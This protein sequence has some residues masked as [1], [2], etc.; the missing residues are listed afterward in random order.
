MT[1]RSCR[2]TSARCEDRGNSISGYL[3]LIHP[4]PVLFVMVGTALFGLLAADGSPE[5]PRFILMLVAMFG[6]QVAIGAHNEWRD[7][8]HDAIHQPEKPIPSGLVEPGTVRPIIGA[9]LLVGAVAGALLGVWPLVLL[10]I[11]TASGFVYN[12]WLKRTPLSGL[13]YLVG[14]PLLPIWT[15][16]VMDR[17]EADL[18]WLY[19]LGGAYVL[20]IHLAQSL[21]DIEGDRRSGTIGLAV[22]LGA[23]RASAAIWLI[24]T[25]TVL[26]MPPRRAVPG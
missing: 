15:T 20:A 16:L 11:G 7:R 21:P 10:L 23:R 9:G 14:L 13:P 8:Q 26:I 25:S 1:S 2:W 18:L 19:P 24:A 3:R 5:P 4:V 12:L 22:A 6:G 17:F